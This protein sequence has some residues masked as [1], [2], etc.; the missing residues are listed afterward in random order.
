MLKTREV[1]IM[2][3]MFL[4]LSIVAGILCAG[5]NVEASRV[6]PGDERYVDEWDSSAADYSVTE[7]VTYCYS[8]VQETLDAINEERKLVGVPEVNLS[9]TMTDE[10]FIRATQC[11]LVYGH[12]GTGTIRD[13][14]LHCGEGVGPDTG[15]GYVAWC[16]ANKTDAHYLDLINKDHKSIGIGVTK[17]ANGKYMTAVELSLDDS[18]VNDEKPELPADYSESFSTGINTNWFWGLGL[19]DEYENGALKEDNSNVISADFVAFTKSEKA[20]QVGI[21]HTLEDHDRVAWSYAFSVSDVQYISPSCV[22]FESLTP[23]IL[24]IDENGTMQGLKAGTAQV[25]VSLKPQEGVTFNDFT[26]SETVYE[27]TVLDGGIAYIDDGDGWGAFPRFLNSSDAYWGTTEE[28]TEAA[29]TEEPT[30][31]QITTTEQATTA[32][33]KV[34]KTTEQPTTEKKVEKTTEQAATSEKK[35]EKKTTEQATVKKTTVTKLSKVK[36][37]KV[38]RGKN[39][40]QVN[41]KTVANAKLYQI[42]ISLNKNMKGRQAYSVYASGIKIAQR[43]DWKGKTVYVRVRAINGNVKGAWSA[44]KK[45]KK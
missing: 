38:K 19:Q 35:V 8:Q 25:K 40:L 15:L 10:A 3:K 20:L 13:D 34:E 42:Q 16:L 12:S 5:M 2:R 44:V 26:V 7:D 11:T 30:T 6:Y 36:N 28:T 43:S 27:I 31:E 23:D 37:L 32:E 17:G 4:G 45:V 41:F 18:Y 24:T 14:A 21:Y 9:K 39:K 1:F 22:T 33:Q 29:T